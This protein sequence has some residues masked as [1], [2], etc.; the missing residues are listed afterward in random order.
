[1]ENDLVTVL[2]ISAIGM[3]LLF[4][5]LILFY[6]IISLLTT[7]TREKR[8]TPPGRTDGME[9]QRDAPSNR[10]RQAAAIAVALA[11]AGAEGQVRKASTSVPMAS[12]D[13]A[14]T[15]WWS[16][17]HQHRLA[18]KGNPRRR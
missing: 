10:A 3:S 7:V 17:H 6:G 12:G 11:R 15:P 8:A 9:K 2:V 18:G 4:L 5:S 14:V 16:L 13:R 1:M